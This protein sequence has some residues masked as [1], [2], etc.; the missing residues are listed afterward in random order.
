MT[1]S[2]ALI[3]M[4]IISISSRII[5]IIINTTMFPIMTFLTCCLRAVF[6]LGQDRKKSANLRPT[7]NISHTVLSLPTTTPVEP[8]VDV[9]RASRHILERARS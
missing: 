6:A 4:A 8:I 2:T 7:P 1:I 3:I 5:N 9:L